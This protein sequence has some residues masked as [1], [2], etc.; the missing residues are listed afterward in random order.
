MLSQNSIPDAT[1]RNWNGY[2]ALTEISSEVN[3]MEAFNLLPDPQTNGGLLFTINPN[4]LN[5][6]ILLLKENGL[7]NF[8]TPIGKMIKK[9][10][11]VIRVEK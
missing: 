10:E 4:S 7:E 2:S 3:V 9:E 1:F 11:K 5:E 8:I 6:I